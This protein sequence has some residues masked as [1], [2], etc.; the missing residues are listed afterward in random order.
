MDDSAHGHGFTAKEYYYPRFSTLDH[1]IQESIK[2]KTFE[3]S[4][5]MFSLP[6]KHFNIFF[7]LLYVAP[8]LKSI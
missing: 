1:W 2:P 4:F 6:K 8:T 7:E 5:F 3:I